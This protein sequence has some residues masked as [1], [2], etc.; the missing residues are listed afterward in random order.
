[1]PWNIPK[2]NVKNLIAKSLL[3]QSLKRCEVPNLNLMN[4][5]NVMRAG[6][7]EEAT[8]S[9]QDG[10]ASFCLQISSQL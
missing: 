4:S 8:P 1:M 10:I 2:I 9:I 6:N 3:I 5:N 7:E